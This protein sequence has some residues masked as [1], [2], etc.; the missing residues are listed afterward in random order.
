MIEWLTFIGDLIRTLELM[1]GLSIGEEKYESNLRLTNNKVQLTD[2][3][4]K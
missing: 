1:G 2:L 4:L 3:Q